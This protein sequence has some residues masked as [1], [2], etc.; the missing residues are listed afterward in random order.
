M[1]V[2]TSWPRSIEQE[3]NISRDVPRETSREIYPLAPIGRAPLGKAL[4]GAWR[5]GE[6]AKAVFPFSLPHK[7]DE[8]LN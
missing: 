5:S 4:E 8:Y 2:D 6:E 1:G 7:G 3:M